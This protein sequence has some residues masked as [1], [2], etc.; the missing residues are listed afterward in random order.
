MAFKTVIF[1]FFVPNP[2]PPRKA[3][4]AESIIQVKII[5]S[6]D[7]TQVKC[8][9]GSYAIICVQCKAEQDAIDMFLI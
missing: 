9:H 5:T 2:M 6:I 7:S 4:P 8:N 1:L 3:G